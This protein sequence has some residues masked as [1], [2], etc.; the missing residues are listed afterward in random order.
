MQ[1]TDLVVYVDVDDTLV[2]QTGAKR[3]P[4]VAA[5]DRDA[6]VSSTVQRQ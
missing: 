2:R 4:M 1:P 5:V 3:I 6:I